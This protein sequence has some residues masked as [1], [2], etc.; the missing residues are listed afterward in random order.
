MGISYTLG[1]VGVT[2]L[3]AT[4]YHRF[5]KITI[6]FECILSPGEKNHSI[7]AKTSAGALCPINAGSLSAPSRACN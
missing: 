4:E 5:H 7:R 3:L 1:F 2:V 6:L